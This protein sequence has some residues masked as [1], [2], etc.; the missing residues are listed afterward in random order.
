MLS[1][2]RGSFNQLPLRRTDAANSPLHRAVINTEERRSQLFPDKRKIPGRKAK[3]FIILSLVLNMW[4]VKK[5]VEIRR[6][7]K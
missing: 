6:Q 3:F 1:N 2:F 7:F 4:G 5:V